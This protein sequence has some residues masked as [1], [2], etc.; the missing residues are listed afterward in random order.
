MKRFEQRLF[1][2]TDNLVVLMQLAFWISVY[3]FNESEGKNLKTNIKS[4]SISCEKILK[5]IKPF[6]KKK[7]L[8]LNR[9]SI[10]N[11]LWY[12]MKIY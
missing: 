8:I 1:K 4:E 5:K 10:T 6:L 3:I 7:D 2:K 9:N 11:F 12:Y